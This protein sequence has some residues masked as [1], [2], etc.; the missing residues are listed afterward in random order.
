MYKE[1]VLIHTNQSLT[2]EVG[3]C[4][5][6]RYLYIPIYQLHRGGETEYKEYVSLYANHSITQRR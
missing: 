3:Q 2:Q 6:K 1:D 5:Q 4:I